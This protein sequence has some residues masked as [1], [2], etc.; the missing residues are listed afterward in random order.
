MVNVVS[1][2]RDFCGSPAA[3]QASEVGWRLS[4]HCALCT[5]GNT[6]P[7]APAFLRGEGQKDVGSSYLRQNGINGG[8][9]ISETGSVTCSRSS[10][11]RCELLE[12]EAH[13]L[14]TTHPAN[15]LKV[16]FKLLC[17]KIMP[18]CNCKHQTVN[19]SDNTD[20]F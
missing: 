15:T 10:S 19:R 17:Y 12:D 16:N 8:S 20:L 3:L 4:N 6:N 18:H 7:C 5:S 2:R 11:A 13:E 9:V 1:L 14:Y